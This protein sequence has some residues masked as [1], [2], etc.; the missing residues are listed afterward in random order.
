MEKRFMLLRVLLL[1][2]GIVALIMIPPLIMAIVDEDRVMIRAIALPVGITLIIALPILFSVRKTR[3]QFRARD[4]FLL[5]F[6]TWVLT[7]FMGSIP[8]Y[9][10]GM[11]ISFSDAFFESACGFATTGGTTISDVEALPQSLLL[12]RCMSHWFGGMGIVL[13]TVAL[14]PIL[15][16]GGFQLIKAETPGPEKEKITPKITE[17]AKQL[18]LA[19]C[20]FTLLLL[21][22]FRLGGM[23]WFDA[24][25]HGMV[26]MASG[27]VSTKN[28]GIAYYKSPFIEG[29]STVFMLMAGFNFS[30]YFKLFRGQLRDIRANTE[31]KVY[32]CIF[33]L[34]ALALT[35]ILLP[36]YGS[37]FTAW[38]YASF[39]TA[40]ILSTTG[41]NVVNYALWPPLAQSLLFCLMCIG[42]CSGSTAGGIK[43][44]RHVV[45]FKQ[46]MNELRRAIYP[47]GVFSVQLNHK[48]GRKD[49]VYGVA[50][51]C[52]LY[53]AVIGITTL[54]T[55]A[56]GT[57][58]L[59][60]LS[61]ALSVTGNVGTGFGVIGPD[62]N[63]STFP[64]WLKW[65]FSFVMIA[66]RLELWTVFILFTREYWR[67]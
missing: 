2:M 63:Y 29:V 36:V 13:L 23:N 22:L 17:T 1:L 51:Y 49:V 35:L 31:V 48:V 62:H 18:W 40:S 33:I 9:L 15:G 56:A 44:I 37:P 65:F 11:G 55:A 12:W 10:S 45:L 19:Y 25:C 20:G 61:T 54:V 3:F 14:T 5:V 60:A 58:L 41:S 66:G 8:Y 7:S 53:L 47:Q 30:L 38:R 28:A 59:S 21:G 26:T 34:S 43:V 57:D 24:L 6:L 27:G 67:R 64:D 39:E 16:I 46:S 50:G 32:L 52:F 42:G 4:G